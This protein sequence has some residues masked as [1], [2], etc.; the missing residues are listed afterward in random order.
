[1]FIGV[2][3]ESIASKTSDSD[4]SAM[5]HPPYG[6]GLFRPKEPGEE[7]CDVSLARAPDTRSAISKQKL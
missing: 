7:G 5:H 2:T 4:T 3:W 6:S 1:M